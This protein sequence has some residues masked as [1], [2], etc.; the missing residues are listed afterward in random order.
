[1]RTILFISTI[2]FLNIDLKA[3]FVFH[4]PTDAISV[5][6]STTNNYVVPN[7]I[8]PNGDRY[9]DVFILPEEIIILE[10]RVAIFNRWGKVV[11][12]INNY[13]NDWDG[14][15]LSSGIYYYQVI[16]NKCKLKGTLQ[17]LR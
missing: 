13:K 17:I 5:V 1:M 16:F 2:V 6:D 14:D 11:H 8:T 9:N 15:N 3:Q 10:N 12:K 4:C 7:I